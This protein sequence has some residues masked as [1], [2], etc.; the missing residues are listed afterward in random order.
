MVSGGIFLVAF[1]VLRVL[2]QPSGESLQPNRVW[3]EDAPVDSASL[4]DSTNFVCARVANQPEVIRRGVEYPVPDLGSQPPGGSGSLPE[5]MIQFR[6]EQVGKLLTET[7]QRCGLARS[8]PELCSNAWIEYFT[9]LLFPFGIPLILFVVLLFLWFTCCYV[10]CCRCC[11]RMI[12]CKERSEPKRTSRTYII[13]GMVIW[14]FSS[15][16]NVALCFPLVD[17][18]QSLHV[19]INWN[20][21]SAH[22]FANEILHGSSWFLGMEPALVRFNSAGSAFDAQS[23][24]IRTLNEVLAKSEPFAQKHA[25]LQRRLSHFAETLS[26]MSFGRRLFDHRCVFCNLALGRGPTDGPDAVPP[27]DYPEHGFLTALKEELAQSSAEAIARIR[28]N[29]SEH[30]TGQNL[31]ELTKYLKSANYSFSVFN[32]AVVKEALAYL[33]VKNRPHIDAVEQIR[34]FLF[35]F[36]AVIAGIGAAI[37]WIALIRTRLRSKKSMGSRP[38][39]GRLHLTSWCFAFFSAVLAMFMGSLLFF[40]S[41]PV[42]EACVFVRQDLLTYEGLQRYASVFGVVAPEGATSTEVKAAEEAIR[43]AQACLAQNRTGDMLTAVGL[44]EIL[45]FPSQLIDAFY[46]LDNRRSEAPV[47]LQF[48]DLLEQMITLAEDY[49]ATFI[50][51]PTEIDNGTASWGPLTLNPNVESLLLGSGLTPQDGTAPDKVTRIRGLNSY[52]EL[53]AGPGQYTFLS[54]TAG[55]G[56][57]IRSTRPSEAELASLPLEV[58]NALRYAQNKEKLIAT[59]SAL[60]CNT[61][62]SAGVV[63]VQPCSVAA[64]HAYV[65]SE[66]K[67]IKEAMLETTQEAESIMSLFAVDLKSELL[68]SL[69]SLNGLTSR[70]YCHPMWKR[71]EEL[72]NSLCMDIANALSWSA[73]FSL[74]Q[75]VAGVVGLVVQYKIWRRLKDNK[76]LQEEIRRYEQKLK[77]H[78]RQLAELEKEEREADAWAARPAQLHLD[79]DMDLVDGPK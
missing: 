37:G 49:G 3:P 55:G 46:Q 12:C 56:F 34:H 69:T 51:D 72:D 11:R 38:P 73:V 53:I 28:R 52:A 14:S 47:G 20:L 48:A 50:L 13:C 74:A 15:I 5:L 41:V 27:L 32:E 58:Q 75:A 71:V 24:S 2:C 39:S 4:T 33:W 76:V 60:L 26:A 21:C 54:G 10:A 63:R 44:G 67:L 23:R 62:S 19:S 8:D 36:A 65:V 79:L 9:S 18:S 6:Q 40:L 70:L 17:A 61:L 78:Q 59:T 64:F 7:Q 66:A 35:V 30:L 1:P 45:A 43:L 22:H 42:A 29:T 57:V 77:Q 25:F 31:T 16:L 68:P